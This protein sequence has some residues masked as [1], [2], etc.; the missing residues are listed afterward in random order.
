MRMS[1]ENLTNKLSTVIAEKYPQA[2][3]TVKEVKKNNGT[4]Y[5]GIVTKPN[6][7]EAFPV[8]NV[9]ALHEC[10]NYKE[11]LENALKILSEGVPDT[12]TASVTAD[13]MQWE[14]VRDKVYP[15]LLNSERNEELKKSVVFKDFEDLIVTYYVK[16]GEGTDA[17]GGQIFSIKV[18]SEMLQMW[19]I[20]P[21]ELDKVAFENYSKEATIS[22]LVDV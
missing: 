21:E 9:T 6:G 8:I 1:I 2:T 12:I 3:V 10:S 4:G 5:I 18:T 7:V 16:V 14:N 11:A 19:G 22:S 15:G 13:A 17:H 20:A